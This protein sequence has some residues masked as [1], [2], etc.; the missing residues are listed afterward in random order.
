MGRI[1]PFLVFMGIGTATYA[2]GSFYD[3]N[4][5]YELC[6]NQR[7]SANM[8]IVGVMDGGEFMA[9]I[10]DSLKL[11]CIPD[12]VIARQLTD[13]GCNYLRDHPEKRQYTAASTI[14]G[15]FADTFPCKS[16]K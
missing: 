11:I 9:S 14:L 15:A 16:G 10:N 3:G 6:L 2:E 8:Y 7:A 1:F 4:E 5:L 12:R 13:V